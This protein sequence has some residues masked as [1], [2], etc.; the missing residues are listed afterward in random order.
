MSDP[1]AERVIDR[2]IGAPAM[3]VQ[4]KSPVQHVLEYR[5]LNA[6]GWTN[7]L[8]KVGPDRV[9]A[10]RDAMEQQARELGL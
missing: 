10:Y 4:P 3:T 2:H 6:Q 5:R 7:L 9:R 1:H 8:R